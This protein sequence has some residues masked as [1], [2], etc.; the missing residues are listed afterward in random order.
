[1][2]KSVSTL[3]SAVGAL[4]GVL[5]LALAVGEYR[6]GASAVWPVTAAV[7]FLCASYTLV[8]DLRRAR[9]GTTT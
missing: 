8:R 4:V 2:T 3:I 1:M 5:L 9:T 7:I 6:S